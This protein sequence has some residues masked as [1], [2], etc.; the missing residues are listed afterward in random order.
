[1][2]TKKEKPNGFSFLPYFGTDVKLRHCALMAA[3]DIVYY[4]IMIVEDDAFGSM[5]GEELK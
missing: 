4:K 2:K 5:S 3:E 1:M